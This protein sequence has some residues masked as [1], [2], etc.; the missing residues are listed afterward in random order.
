MRCLVRFW[1][2]RGGLWLRGWELG[3]G[4]RCICEW[5]LETQADEVYKGDEE[6]KVGYEVHDCIFLFGAFFWGFG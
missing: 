2:G 4:G 5:S 1:R 6:G 3:E